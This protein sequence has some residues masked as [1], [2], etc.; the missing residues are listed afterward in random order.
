[1]IFKRFRQARTRVEQ[2]SRGPVAR[3]D[4]NGAFVLFRQSE[5]GRKRHEVLGV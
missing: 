2:A 3:K 1:M 4:R 5:I